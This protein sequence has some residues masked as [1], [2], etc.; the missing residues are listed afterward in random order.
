MTRESSS[1]TSESSHHYHI[2]MY[3]EQ[4]AAIVNFRFEIESELKDEMYSYFVND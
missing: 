4:G 1:T 3:T 2:S